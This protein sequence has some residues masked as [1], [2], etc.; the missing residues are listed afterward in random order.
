MVRADR[1]LLHRVGPLL[2][3]TSNFSTCL[4]VC[5]EHS[6]LHVKKNC[7]KMALGGKKTVNH[8]R[9]R[10]DGRQGACQKANSA[11]AEGECAQSR[12]SSMGE[13]KE[14]KPVDPSKQ[15]ALG[16]AIFTP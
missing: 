12:A 4:H 10:T 3:Y 15:V 6:Y 14:E 8:I 7:G 2:L 13:G 16:D 1:V 5:Q 11:R 9:L